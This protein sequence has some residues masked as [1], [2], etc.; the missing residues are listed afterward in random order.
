[1]DSHT[2]R[3][4]IL[5]GAGH[6]VCCLCFLPL[7][8]RTKVISVSPYLNGLCIGD[9]FSSITT[10]PEKY[11]SSFF[12]E[13]YDV[14]VKKMLCNFPSNSGLFLRESH[15]YSYFCNSWLQPEME[16]Q[17]GG[18]GW[19]Q[20]QPKQASEKRGAPAILPTGLVFTTETEVKTSRAFPSCRVHLFVVFLKSS[21]S[22]HKE[23]ALY[24]CQICYFYDHFCDLCL[25]T[26]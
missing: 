23:F 26:L 9:W 22:S 10:V 1:M 8:C 4:V 13:N 17:A 21:L 5:D 18:A 19:I 25:E 12:I 2:G 20:A 3:A 7:R 24:S 15:T 6:E 11:Q 14:V 16:G